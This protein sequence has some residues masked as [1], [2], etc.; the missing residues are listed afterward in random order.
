MDEQ[1]GEHWQYANPGRL[2]RL[3]LRLGWIGF[4]LQFAL[5][6]V[7]IVLTLYVMIFGAPTAVQRSAIDV[8]NWL[9]TGSLLVL[10]FTTVWFYRYVRL[11]RSFA[12]PDEVPRPAKVQSILWV[13]LWA[14]FVGILFSTLLMFGA[15]GR[16]LMTLMSQPQIG[17][18]IAPPPGSDTIASITVID[19]VSLMSLVVVLFAELV[20]LALTLWLL[21]RTMKSA[22]QAM[23]GAEAEL[24]A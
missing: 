12:E 6:A 16:L 21:L 8:E 7:V 15:V 2:G 20:V 10:L 4:W 19:A 24:V 3:F 22:R 9:S 1:Y 18:M 23:V 5:L 11:G 14:G 17:I 13:G